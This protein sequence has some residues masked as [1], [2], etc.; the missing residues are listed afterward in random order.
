MGGH[1]GGRFERV[2]WDKRLVVTANLSRRQ[3]W[4]ME[5]THHFRSFLFH[6]LSSLCFAGRL[7]PLISYETRNS[8]IEQ[9]YRLQ[10]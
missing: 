7:A 6:F 2:N 8:L 9:T 5:T 10:C 3:H 1:A 4:T